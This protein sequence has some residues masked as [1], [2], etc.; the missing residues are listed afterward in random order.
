MDL[1]QAIMTRVSHDLSGIAGALYNTTEL[2]ELDPSFGAEAGSVL[3]QSTG[4]LLA[5]LRFFRALFGL[6]S[7]TVTTDLALHY[8]K[9][10]SAPLTLAGSLSTR[11]ELGAVLIVAESLIRGGA[12]HVEKGRVIGTGAVTLDENVFD[13]LSNKA[14]EVT[15]RSAPAAWMCQLTQQEGQTLVCHKRDQEIILQWS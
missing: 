12:I 1:T 15:P 14:V 10:L 6:P 5:R 8:L 4:Y 13:V 3:K 9:T 7:A 2:L 11:Q